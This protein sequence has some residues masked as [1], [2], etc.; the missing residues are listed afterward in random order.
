MPLPLFL[1]ILATALWSQSAIIETTGESRQPGL[2]LFDFRIAGIQGWTLEKGTLFLHRHSGEPP[3]SLT[4]QLGSTRLTTPVT[5]L[6]QQWMSVELPA[7]VLTALTSGTSR[8]GIVEDPAWT[9]H[10]RGPAYVAPY[11]LAEAGRAR[12]SGVSPIRVHMIRLRPGD[13]LLRSLTAYARDKQIRAAIILTA[14]GSLTQT[15]LRFAD[16]PDST[17]RFAKAEIVSLTGTLDAS[18]AHLHLSAADGEGRTFGGHLVEGCRI[19]TTAEIALG[20]LTGL[21]FSREKDKASGYDELKIDA[22][23]P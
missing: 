20:E 3:A 10:G 2:R 6:P 22:G 7:P 17:A 21:R 18:S 4:L 1:W 16:K 15:R 23:R 8:L 12:E 14:S 9:L 11:I 19:Y 13:D 5:P